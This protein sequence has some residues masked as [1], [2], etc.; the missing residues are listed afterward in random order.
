MN[1]MAIAIMPAVITQL[2][3]TWMGTAITAIVIMTATMVAAITVVAIGDTVAIMAAGGITMVGG[4]AAIIAAEI[5]MA[6]TVMEE[7]MKAA[8]EGMAGAPIMT[9]AITTAM[10]IGEMGEPVIGVEATVGAAVM[11]GI[12]GIED[13]RT[14][15][16]P[17]RQG[18]QGRLTT[19]PCTVGDSGVLRRLTLAKEMPTDDPI[20]QIGRTHQP[21]LQR[22]ER[23]GLQERIGPTEPKV[24]ALPHGLL[25]QPGQLWQGLRV[26]HRLRLHGPVLA[27]HPGQQ[28]GPNP[29]RALG[30]PHGRPG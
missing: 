13:K 2:E 24:R 6:D 28:R 3:P 10:D 27:Q 22:Q 29:G 7:G 23:K 5:M 18:V 19:P 11:A 16:H 14:R 25:S 26:S 20:G 8:G 21:G 9:A 12:M 17:L 4:M 15:Q 30:K 1:P